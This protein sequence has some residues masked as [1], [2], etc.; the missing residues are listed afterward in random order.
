MSPGGAPH[1][2]DPAPPAAR[3]AFACGTSA[4][5]YGAAV[6]AKWRRNAARARPEPGWQGDI[7]GDGRPVRARRANQEPNVRARL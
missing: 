6:S 1:R 7:R 2:P 5:A 4:R 3:A